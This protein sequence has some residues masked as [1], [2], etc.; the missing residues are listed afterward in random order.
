MLIFKCCNLVSSLNMPSLSRVNLGEDA[1]WA[2]RK[3]MQMK[4]A[5]FAVLD[6]SLISGLSMNPNQP[7]PSSLDPRDGHSN[8]S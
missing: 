7:F 3:E 2:L 6:L 5:D 8:D 1:F 4:M